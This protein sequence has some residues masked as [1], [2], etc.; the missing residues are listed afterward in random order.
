[1]NKLIGEIQGKFVEIVSYKFLRFLLKFRENFSDL[2]GYVGQVLLKSWA[3]EK[4]AKKIF[5]TLW[6]KIFVK[7]ENFGGKK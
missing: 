6:V 2:W 5:T 1:M 7:L 4:I 3:F